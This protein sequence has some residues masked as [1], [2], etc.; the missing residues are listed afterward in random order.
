M[1]RHAPRDPTP[2]RSE[3]SPPPPPSPPRRACAGSHLVAHI[4]SYPCIASPP[5]GPHYL[6]DPTQADDAPAGQNT[7]SL[8]LTAGPAGAL[9]ASAW[10]PYVVDY[11]RAMSVVVH[12]PAS[13]A[14][15]AC[16]DLTPILPL[17]P[18]VWSAT[19]EANIADKSYTSVR[20]EYFHQAPPAPAPAVLR[21]L[22]SPSQAPACRPADRGCAAAPPGNQPGQRRGAQAGGEAGVHTRLQ[23]KHHLLRLAERDLPQRLLR[24]LDREAAVP[25][26]LWVWHRDA[27]HCAVSGHGQRRAA[28]L[29]HLCEP[30][31]LPLP[32]P[33]GAGTELLYQRTATKNVRGINTRFW[34][35]DFSIPQFGN[36][37]AGEAL[38]GSRLQVDRRTGRQADRR[39]GGQRS[40]L[41]RRMRPSHA[42][43]TRRSL[44]LSGGGVEQR[45]GAV[46]PAAEGACC[47]AAPPPLRSR[48]P[49]RRAR[50]S[51]PRRRPSQRVEV[52]GTLINSTSNSTYSIAHSYEFT[53]FV[54]LIRNMD[55]FNPCFVLLSGGLGVA[56][57]STITGCGCDAHPPPLPAAATVVYESPPSKIYGVGD[58]VGL[59]IGTTIM[60]GIVGAAGALVHS[61]QKQ[62]GEPFAQLAGSGT[63]ADGRL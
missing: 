2:T 42:P 3:T 63:A 15:L 58:M 52:N 14:R 19:I 41:R 55:V 4:H 6:Q 13:L 30:S 28:A 1:H 46:P 26:H 43:R 40:R 16:V 61:R 27:N 33:R 34:T 5:G 18:N 37:S 8:N 50:S 36:L 7:F 60:G 22:A 24:L 39:T 9:S 11:D 45:R 17:L 21:G 59:A 32:S 56:H 47:L 35:R 49:F 10:R 57:N 54:P 31:G 44:L 51:A 62:G 12:D 20:K 23:H 25:V 38:S 29:P 48:L 53:D